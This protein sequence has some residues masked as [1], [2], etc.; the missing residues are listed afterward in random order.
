MPNEKPNDPRHHCAQ[1]RLQGDFPKLQDSSYFITG[2]VFEFQVI[3]LFLNSGFALGDSRLDSCVKG[4]SAAGQY[5]PV[6]CWPA[7][8]IPVRNHTSKYF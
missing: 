2:V 5:P 8:G 3:E 7:L 1:M 6:G 4:C